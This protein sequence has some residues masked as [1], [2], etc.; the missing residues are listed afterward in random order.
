MRDWRR[1][2]K[3]KG[4]DAPVFGVGFLVSGNKRT[5]SPLRESYF[6]TCVITYY[7]VYLT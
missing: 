4:A 5:A 2:I 1:C 7:V 3:N 6:L